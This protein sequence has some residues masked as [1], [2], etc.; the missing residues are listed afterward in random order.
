MFFFFGDCVQN[1]GVSIRSFGVCCWFIVVNI[2]RYPSSNAIGL[3]YLHLI[4]LREVR[5]IA[6]RITSE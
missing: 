6:G 2:E 1:I 3:L 5:K 4:S